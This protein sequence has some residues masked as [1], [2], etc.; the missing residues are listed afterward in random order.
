MFLIIKR[1]LLVFVIIPFAVPGQIIEDFSDGEI[2]SNPSWEGNTSLFKVNTSKQL[3]LD[4]DD[5]GMAS[6]YT[7][8]SSYEEMEWR[9]WIKQSFS[10]SANNHSRVYLFAEEPDSTEYPDG[11]FIQFG[12]SG[13]LDAIRLMRQSEGDTSTLIC[14]IQGTI[15]TS[16][17]CRIRV[18]CKQGQWELLVDHTG[19]ENYFSEGSCHSNPPEGSAFLGISCTYTSSNS[20]KFYFDDI[21]AGSLIAD[22]IPPE[23]IDINISGHDNLEIYF[24]E[25]LAESSIHTSANY[26]IEPDMLLVTEANL[27]FSDPSILNLLLN[28]SIPYGISFRLMIKDIQDLS[29]N[30]MALCSLQFAD[31]VPKPYDIVINEIMADPSPP[32]FLPEIEYLELYNTTALPIDLSGWSLTIGSSEKVFTKF[33]MEPYTYL[34]TGREDADSCFSPFG[35]FYGFESFSLV[36]SGQS[37]VLQD[38]RGVIISSLYYR[39]DWYK[40]AQKSGGGWSLEQINP[41]N[42]CLSD[43]NW[44]ASENN[45][46]GS[47][48]KENSVYEDMLIYPEITSACVQDAERIRILFNQS[49]SVDIITNPSSFMINH[50][51]GCPQYIMPENYL[52]NSFILYPET[53]LFESVI[54]ELSCN[55]NMANCKGDSGWINEKVMIGIPQ[56]PEPEDIVINEVLFNP[57]PGGCDYVELYNRSQKPIELSSVILASVK[58]NP[59]LPPDTSF[60]ELLTDC[61]VIMPGTYMLLCPSQNNVEAYYHWE[62]GKNYYEPASF[63][64][65]NNE[66]GVVL[67][68]DRTKK[69]IDHFEYHED[70]HYPLLNITEGVS[71][72]RIHF[73]RPSSD[74]TN[75][76]SASQLSGFGTPGYQNSQ[77]VDDINENESI[78]V[79]PRIFTPGYDGKDDHV[80]ISFNLNASGQLA[81]II[82][83]NSSGKVIRHLVNNEMLGVSGFYSWNGI[84]DRGQKAPAGIYI[85]LT[86]LTDI[87][88]NIA[89]YKNTVVIAPG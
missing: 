51:I 55:A 82:I 40:D 28:D 39:D 10:P 64:S 35:V 74:F 46:G 45:S 13:S 34:I 81:T 70:M 12:E 84:D 71:L 14:G 53:P 8:I 88:G 43:D 50:G 2:T 41:D 37:L 59:P 72:E 48:G 38:E 89:R 17:S 1:C 3:Q 65:Y 68:L 63:P 66:S 49:M 67:L 16:F 42:P 83:F 30:E 27:S 44:R 60:A 6:I 85:I 29:G 11:F 36:N 80:N 78:Q 24:S 76:H 15:A 20:T 61:K 7:G 79:E 22:T 52:F 58:N 87:R 73:D 4:D 5:A 26:F 21:Y 75:W 25:S 62:G 23:A 69:C 57:F 77:F 31:Y 56:Q 32:Q 19:D 33:S 18:V 86:E 47:P 54:Y 9:F